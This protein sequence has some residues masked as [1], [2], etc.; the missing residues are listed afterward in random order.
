M[1]NSEFFL[2]GEY[3]ISLPHIFYEMGST[4]SQCVNRNPAR[5]VLLGLD[6]SGKTTILYKFL[7]A[8]ESIETFPTVGFNKEQIT[9][10]HFSM[11]FWDFG[12]K[13]IVK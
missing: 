10:K 8:S 11:L 4:I 2:I 7:R 1:S 6:A 13:M 5:I 3:F 9:Y 12:G